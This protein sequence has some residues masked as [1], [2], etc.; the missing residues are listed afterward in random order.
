KLDFQDKYSVFLNGDHPIVEINT[1]TN[2]PRQLL[3]IKDSYA[4]SMVPYLIESYSK[5]T[6]VD[7]KY[8]SNNLYDLISDNKFTDVLF[9]YNANT[10]FKDTSLVNLLNS[11]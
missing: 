3:L 11:K 1:T 8:Y 7:P 5:I 6:I 10:F 2:T 4:N 9:L